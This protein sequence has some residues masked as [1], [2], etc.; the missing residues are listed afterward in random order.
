MTWYPGGTG[1]AEALHANLK[2]AM[3]SAI[4]RLAGCPCSGG[5]PSC[6]GV[7]IASA[8]NKALSLQLLR[9]LH[10]SLES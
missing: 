10:G 5:C 8:E 6:I 7:E 3:A 2:E 9:L 4:E 1:I